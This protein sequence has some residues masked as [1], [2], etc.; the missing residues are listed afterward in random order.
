METIVSP[1]KECPSGSDK[2]ITLDAAVRYLLE[3]GDESARRAWIVDAL[4]TFPPDELLPFLKS[5]AERN[6]YIDPNISLCLAETLVAAGEMAGRP[7]HQALGLMQIG[8]VYRETG[9][10]HESVATLDEAGALFLAHGNEVGWARTRTGWVW[11]SH[12]LGNGEAALEAVAHAYDILAAHGLWIRAAAF[13]LNAGWVCYELGNYEQALSH[14][15]RAQDAYELLGASGEWGIAGTKMN[16][17]ILLGEL[18]DFQT[19]LHLHEE[20]RQYF[21]LH[22][23]TIHVLKQEHNIALIYSAQGHYTRALHHHAAVVAEYDRAGREYNA[24]VVALIM[25]E[26]YLSLNRNMEALELAEELIARFERLRTPNEAAKARFFSAL[27]HARLGSLERALGLLDEVTQAFVAGGLGSR[28]ALV[29]LQRATFHLE[30]ENWPAAA[31]EAE[32]AGALLAERGLVIRKAQADLV[33]ARAAL[34][35]NDNETAAQFAEAALLTAQ[36]R[37]VRWLAHEGQHILGGVA[38]ARGDLPAALDAYDRAVT[39]IEQLQSALAIEL[40]THF[41]A[42]KLRVYEDAIAA[43]LALAMPER[44]FGYLE[45]AKSRALV[46]YLASNLEVQIRARVSTNQELVETLARLREEHNWFYNRLYG[47]QL[48]ADEKGGA[49]RDEGE[50]WRAAIREREKQIARILERLSLDRTEGLTVLVPDAGESAALPCLAVG[51]V[52]LEYYLTDDT[53]AIFVVAPTGL[54]VVPLA[55]RPR[56]IRRLLHQWQLNLAATAAAIRSGGPLDGLGRNARG[57]LAALHR[58]LIAPVAM[59]LAG[60]ARL[61]IVPYGPTHAVPFHALYDGARY[62]LEEIE[63]SVCP[64]SKLLALCAARPRRSAQS[65]LVVAYSD[66]GRL[67]AVI[68]EARAVAALLPGECLV[69]DE[70]TR[71]AVIA[72]APRHAVIHLAAHGEARVD[73]PTFAHLRLADG[74]LSMMDIFNLDLHGTLVTLSACE[75][76][77]SVV[78]GGDELIGLSRGFL[79]AGASTLVQSLWRGSTRR[80]GRGIRRVPRSARRSVRC[81]PRRASIRTT[82]RHSNSSVIAA[83]WRG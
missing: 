60:Y 36:E 63:V 45:R 66:T 82:G 6:L 41:L 67:P 77:R 50:T 27:A 62:L 13:D 14:Y 17:A 31:E 54:A 1:S 76:G 29:A 73:N 79:Y 18:G 20:S 55:A 65:A 49:R 15:K 26:C 35:L 10:F 38:R 23:Q 16:T 39:S 59:H 9:R 43:S 7:D 69:E 19:A 58:A 34:N 52:L 74:Q 24:G 33:R 78:A 21:A 57:I 11:S 30:D 61:V 28:L 8:E 72:A 68:A 53:G 47:V 37:D 51:T 25:V 70:A 42:D 71:A 75:T 56:D 48:D 40:R 32:R 80:S 2:P 22:G 46:D 44:A 12:R 4:A 64:S 3:R 83:P 81:L 5:E